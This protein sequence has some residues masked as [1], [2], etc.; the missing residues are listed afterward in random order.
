MSS[1]FVCQ[2]CP[3]LQPSISRQRALPRASAPPLSSARRTT[4]KRSLQYV[5]PTDNGPSFHY[6]PPPPHR[7]PLRR[8]HALCIISVCPL[9]R[10]RKKKSKRY[11]REEA[12]LVACWGETLP[13]PSAEAPTETQKKK[14]T[15]KETNLSRRPRRYRM[16]TAERRSC[17][18]QAVQSSV[19]PC[20]RCFVALQ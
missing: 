1:P 2:L 11:H 15:K 17:C 13:Q 20:G 8:G 10:T 6:S 5:P 14:R 16:L 3:P 7:A 19:Q 4:H 18:E 9:P 12:A